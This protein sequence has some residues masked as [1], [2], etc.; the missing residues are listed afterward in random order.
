M[1]ALRKIEELA[2][3]PAGW[4]SD[5]AV[6]IDPTCVDVAYRTLTALMIG[7]PVLIP[8]TVVPTT[9]GGVQLEWHSGGVDV[10]ISVEP[11]ELE[12]KGD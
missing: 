8:P 10:E 9:T 1:T 6:K 12:T 5:G 4:D 7:N 3:L 11:T 2:S